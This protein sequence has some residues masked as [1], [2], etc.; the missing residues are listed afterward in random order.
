MEENILRQFVSIMYYIY[1]IA[2][3]PSVDLDINLERC[4]DIVWAPS[5]AN[6]RKGGNKCHTQD[7]SRPLGIGL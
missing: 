2:P 5:K 3:D 1:N 4:N 6:K 7:E